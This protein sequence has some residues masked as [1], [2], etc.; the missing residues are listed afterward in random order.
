MSNHGEQNNEWVDD[1]TIRRCVA[2]AK[3]KVEGAVHYQFV[4]VARDQTGTTMI[5]F[6]VRSR[7]LAP[8]LRHGTISPLGVA[9]AG[10]N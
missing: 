8:L 7:R 4:C 1:S 3:E 2:F 5:S 6:T 9:G 10:E